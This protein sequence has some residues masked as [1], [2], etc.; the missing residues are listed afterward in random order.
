MIESLILSAMIE[1]LH[2]RHQ[3]V[4]YLH[5]P[6]AEAEERYGSIAADI[7]DVVSD[8]DEPPLFDGPAG[9]EATGLLLAS[10]AWHESGFR[11]DVDTCKGPMSMGDSGRS[12]GL[13]QII[14]GPNREGHTTKE[15]C[16][17]RKLQLR[18]GLHVLR[19]AKNT[20]AGGPLAWLQSYGAGGCNIRNNVARD[21]CAAFERVG[22]KRFVGL[23]CGSAGPVSLREPRTGS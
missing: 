18:L 17:D 11:K 16:A 20:C 3:A 12:V 9:R 8:E 22:K 5:E 13:L 10:I 6:L 1:L 23:S 15:I 7:G 2:P 4:S 14:E 19:R 21:T